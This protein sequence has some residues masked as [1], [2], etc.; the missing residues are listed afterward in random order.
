MEV[1]QR[2][3]EKRNELKGGTLRGKSAV[4]KGGG[5]LSTA[6][7]IATINNRREKVLVMKRNLSK[8]KD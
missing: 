3:R 6:E 1:F 4:L 8:G 5:G 7:L 2:I